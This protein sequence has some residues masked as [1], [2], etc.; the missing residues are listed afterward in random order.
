MEASR[1]LVP[2]RVDH[3]GGRGATT[4]SMDKFTPTIHAVRITR[5]ERV[6]SS[7]GAGEHGAA[8]DVCLQ[9]RP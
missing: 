6:A 5:R 9:V 7:A 4:S 2:D 1:A 3:N 8:N